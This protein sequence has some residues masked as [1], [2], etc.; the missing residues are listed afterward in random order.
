M[1]LN[2][3]P[4][5]DGNAVALWR[6]DNNWSSAF[7]K[8]DRRATK[9]HNF[10][11]SHRKCE[12]AFTVNAILVPVSLV[13]RGR[14]TAPFVVHAED[15]ITNCAVLPPWLTITNSPSFSCFFTFWHVAIVGKQLSSS[16][17]LQK[18]CWHRHV[19]CRKIL[20]K[21]FEFTIVSPIEN[22]HN[23]QHT[24]SSSCSY[25]SLG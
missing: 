17:L 15:Y 11:R 20:R 18:S 4:V 5:H 21:S 22:I 13:L 24:V 7:D 19:F 6:G 9:R 16:I 10:R 2:Y 1:L 12:C 25:H 23:C 8:N 14:K 3:R